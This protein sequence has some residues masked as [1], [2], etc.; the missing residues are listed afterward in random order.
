MPPWLEGAYQSIAAQAEA[1]RKR[2]YEPYTKPRVAQLSDYPEYGRANELAAQSVGE[3]A[4]YLSRASGLYNRAAETFPEHAEAY[5]NPY[6]QQVIKN[7]QERAGETFKEQIL[8][9]LE[10]TFVGAGQHGS[11]RHQEL[12]A[13]AARDMQKAVNEQT[14][15]SL[16]HG[17]DMAGKLYNADVARQGEIAQGIGSLGGLSQAGRLADIALLQEIG[18]MQHGEQQN[19]LNLQY[20]DWLNQQNYPW[21]QL[22]QQSA[23]LHGVPET[24]QS[25]GASQTQGQPQWNTAGNLLNL[26]GSI[27]GASRGYP[28]FGRKAGGRIKAKTM[29]IPKLKGL[30][31]LDVTKGK[32]NGLK[33]KKERGLGQKSFTQSSFVRQPKVGAKSKIK[34][35]GVL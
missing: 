2:E 33:A 16:M 26:A 6:Q 32:F 31:S 10:S 14:A 15:Q 11:M 34:K 4:P 19:K 8:P 1:L 30:S 22:S 27:Y 24:K 21:N 25:Y 35:Q 17:Y 5:M 12:A 20:Q 29:N 3:Y 13:R 7:L 23:L 18:G 28:N 9:Q